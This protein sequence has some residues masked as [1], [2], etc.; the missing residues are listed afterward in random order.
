MNLQAYFS[1]I[2]Y[3]GPATVDL[4]TLREIHLRHLLHIPYENLDVQLRHP[5]DLNVERIYNKIVERQRGGWC[6]EMNGL[7]GWALQ[8][9]G[10]EVTRMAGAVMRAVEGEGQVGNHLV[11]QVMLDQPYLA[12]VGLGDGLREPIP[13]REGCYQQEFLH[14]RLEHLQD[15]YW[16]L[17]N[18]PASNVSSFDFKQE[19]ASEQLLANKCQ[20][21]QTAEESPFKKLFIAYRFTPHKVLTQLGKTFIEVDAGGTTKT[22]IHDLS[23]FNSHMAKTF[24]LNEDFGELWPSITAAHERFMNANERSGSD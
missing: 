15:G 4:A 8:T 21:L 16:R 10:F 19:P 13:L 22:D 20:W 18:H 14:Y 3:A 5:V 7:L 1:R 11:L 12:D 24:G 6:Y 9:I 2:H 17:H 23:A